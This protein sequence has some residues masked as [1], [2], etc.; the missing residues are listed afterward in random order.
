[1][2]IDAHQHFWAFARGDYGWM[3][4]SD[5]LAP[6]RRD[7]LPSELRPILQRH[8]IDKDGIGPSGSD[9]GG[10]ALHAGPR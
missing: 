1:M 2:R 9:G 10:N 6:M 4:T 7:V 8:G 3:G 5:A